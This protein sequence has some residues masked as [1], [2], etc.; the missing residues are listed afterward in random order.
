[1]RLALAPSN[2]TEAVAIL[3][4]RL[5]IAPDIAEATW[6]VAADPVKGLTPDAKLDV[7]GLRNVLAL[8]AELIGTWGG[9]APDPD[10]YVDLSYYQRALAMLK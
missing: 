2:R 8:R 1:L 10:R 7:D 3:A 4:E 6:D 9:T 5:K